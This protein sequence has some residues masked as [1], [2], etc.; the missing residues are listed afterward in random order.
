MRL[1]VGGRIL[2]MISMG[3]RRDMRV[4]KMRVGEEVPEAA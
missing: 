1:G 3:R 2:S 4:A